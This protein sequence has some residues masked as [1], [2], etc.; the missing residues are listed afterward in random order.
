LEVSDPADKLLCH[1]RDRVK[2]IFSSRYRSGRGQHVGYIM[3]SK[4]Q[5]PDPAQ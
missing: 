5:A 3:I 1:E 4:S 2:I